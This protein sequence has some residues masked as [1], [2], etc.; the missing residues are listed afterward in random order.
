MKFT[1]GP[2]IEIGGMSLDVVHVR[3]RK[4]NTA[5]CGAHHKCK[6]FVSAAPPISFNFASFYNARP[7]PPLPIQSGIPVRSQSSLSGC[8][9]KAQSYLL[10]TFP[11]SASAAVT[12]KGT[13]ASAL[14]VS[15]SIAK[16]ADVLSSFG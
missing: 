3:V 1:G 13:T 7:P 8:A 2:D 4:P 11:L 9:T 15:Q 6:V 10:V 5:A 14:N 16:Y 12:Y